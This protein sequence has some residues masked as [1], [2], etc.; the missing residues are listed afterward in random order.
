MVECLRGIFQLLD[1][2]SASVKVMDKLRTK[3]KE[4]ASTVCWIARWTM[5]EC[6]SV[7]YGPKKLTEVMDKK[8]SMKALEVVETLAAIVA[9]SEER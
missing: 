3:M 7:F 6:A 4:A 5:S 8:A 9:I 1:N 2:N